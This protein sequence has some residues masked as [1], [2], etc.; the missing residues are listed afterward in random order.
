M[1]DLNIEVALSRTTDVRAPSIPFPQRRA[2]PR[3]FRPFRLGHLRGELFGTL[4]RRNRSVRVGIAGAGDRHT[5][6]V[7][8]RP[9]FPEITFCIPAAIPSS[10]QRRS[11]I[12]DDDAGRRTGGN[13]FR[14]ASIPTAAETAPRTTNLSSVTYNV[15]LRSGR[16]TLGNPSDNLPILYLTTPT[17]GIPPSWWELT[18]TRRWA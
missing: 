3:Q 2:A 4:H 18:R 17:D 7:L 8:R 10:A 16:T 15:A 12:A 13:P 14:H 6:F 11:G 5:E 1:V 9:R